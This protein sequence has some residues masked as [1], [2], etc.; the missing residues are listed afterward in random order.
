[1]QLLPIGWQIIALKR[2]REREIE[3]RERERERERE[4]G[5][6]E[7]EREMIDYISSVL[8]NKERPMRLCSVRRSR[9]TITTRN[10]LGKRASI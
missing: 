5:G 8:L 4:R 10:C 6:G 2:E 1:M 7:R 9:K 3:R